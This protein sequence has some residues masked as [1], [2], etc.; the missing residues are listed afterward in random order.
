MGVAEHSDILRHMATRTILATTSCSSR[1]AVITCPPRGGPG[2]LTGGG[3]GGY[4]MEE[5]Q[6][7]FV[8][9]LF[10]GVP[11]GPNRTPYA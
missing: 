6:G 1:A 11:V 4:F 7:D 8:K 3:V 2:L 9:Y 5:T 10:L